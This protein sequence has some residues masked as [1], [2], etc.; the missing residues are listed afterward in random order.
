[1]CHRVRETSRIQKGVLMSFQ[2]K[3]NALRLQAFPD[4][5]VAGRRSIIC[6]LP[7]DVNDN[8]IS[9]S[10]FFEAVKGVGW[11]YGIG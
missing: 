9:V 4:F 10:H 1:M 3:L 11:D 5:V 8:G 2:K 6:K 7:T